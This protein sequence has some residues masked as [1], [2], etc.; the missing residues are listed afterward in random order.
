MTYHRN[1]RITRARRRLIGELEDS[2]R[3]DPKLAATAIAG[4]A[5]LPPEAKSQDVKHCSRRV[6][7][8]PLNDEV[9]T[10]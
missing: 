10:S 1:K 7:A 5:P 9:S 3:V 8:N 6:E 4:F 2:K